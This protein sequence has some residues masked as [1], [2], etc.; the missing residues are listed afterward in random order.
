MQKCQNCSNLC[1]FSCHCREDITYI[2]YKHSSEH[3]SHK[4]LYFIP[5]SQ[6]VKEK[7]PQLILTLNAKKQELS[8]L[9]LKAE[10]ITEKCIQNIYSA[11]E[12]TQDIINK[13]IEDLNKAIEII[14]STR[15]DQECN[16]ISLYSL[17][18]EENYEI[19]D[20]SLVM[21]T[22]YYKKIEKWAGKLFYV[23]TYSGNYLK[24]FKY[25]REDEQFIKKEYE[26]RSI[27]TQAKSKKKFFKE[28]SSIIK[29]VKSHSGNM[30]LLYH[31][32]NEKCDQNEFTFMSNMLSLCCK[33]LHQTKLTNVKLTDS[34]FSSFAQSLNQYNCVKSL[35]L[36]DSIMNNQ[37]VL[38]LSEYLKK[39]KNLKSFIIPNNAVCDAGIEIIFASLSGNTQLKAIDLSQNFITITGA[40]I[41]SQ[42]L[43]QF[44]NLREL[45]L[46]NNKLETGGA[47]ILSKTLKN[48]FNLEV[49][50]IN[51]NKMMCEGITYIVKSICFLPHLCVLD[52]WGNDIYDEG[53]LFL[54]EYLKYMLCLSRLYVD[55][56][57]GEDVKRA[58]ACNAVKMC[59]IV[60]KNETNRLVIK[61]PVFE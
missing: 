29:M 30:K 41:L 24:N 44:N 27:L 16:Y 50:F 1:D 22:D 56:V 15:S 48:L 37:Q 21:F 13:S 20:S 23:K 14:L 55:L 42:I 47:I 2:C 8:D 46:N 34:Q 12:R 35:E 40:S 5:N 36:D 58:I 53:G 25:I 28:L 26:R 10:N 33:N 17:I 57:M 39:S 3:L 61:A 32:I 6:M 19:F 59:K 38:I 7:F 43:P 52:M 4:D 18:F 9:I 11:F 49:L 51:R 54:A 31:N 45:T 60:G